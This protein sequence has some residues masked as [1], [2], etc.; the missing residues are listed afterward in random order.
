LADQEYTNVFVDVHKKV[1]VFKDRLRKANKGDADLR[2]DKL[3]RETKEMEVVDKE[4][5]SLN[6]LTLPSSDP[7]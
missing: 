1:K 6:S 7:A 5:S 3:V 2:E 4:S